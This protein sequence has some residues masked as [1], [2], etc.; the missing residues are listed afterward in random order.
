[1]NNEDHE[2]DDVDDEDFKHWNAENVKKQEN[3]CIFNIVSLSCF[4]YV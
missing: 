4:N 2:D 3:Q 1:M